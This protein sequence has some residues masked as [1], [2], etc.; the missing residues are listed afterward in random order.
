M[1]A[2]S[3]FLQAGAPCRTYG[4]VV[5]DRLRARSPCAGW[6]VDVDLAFHATG[7][8]DHLA[9]SAWA[10]GVTV[11]FSGAWPLRAAERATSVRVHLTA[12]PHMYP[13]T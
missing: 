3:W 8:I 2:T 7:A 5:F 11:E 1:W 13:G 4:R 12:P 10:R 6:S 9:Y